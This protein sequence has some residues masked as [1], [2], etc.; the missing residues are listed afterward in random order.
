MN[1]LK[2]N[3][4][5]ETTEERTAF[6]NAY[7]SS[8]EFKKI[9]PTKDELETC[10][11]YILWG[12]DA[13][14]KSS[15]QR[16]EIEIET[17]N[18]TWAKHKDEESLDGLLE[19]P[20]FSEAAHIIH[21]PVR[22]KQPKII[23]SRE[24]ALRDA[25]ESLRQDFIDLFKQIDTLELMVSTYELAHGKRKKPIRKE[26]LDNFSETEI[27]RVQERTSHINQ[28]QYLKLKH[29][30]VEQR[31]LQFTLK[32]GY[33]Q[34]IQR[35]GS[36]L[37][38][39]LEPAP[40][41]NSEVAV[42]PLGTKGPQTKLVFQAIGHLVPNN[43]TEDE[44]SEI[45]K[46]IWTKDAEEKTKKEDNLFF[47]FRNLE[48]VYNFI[49]YF[50]ELEDAAQEDGPENDTQSVLDT[51]QYY[52]EACGFEQIYLDIIEMKKEGRKNQDIADYVNQKYGKS[53]TANYISTIFRQK[54]IKKFIEVVEYHYQVISNLF[55]KENFK[56]CNTCGTVYLTCANNFVRKNRAKDGFSNKCKICDKNERNLK[57][58][59][60]K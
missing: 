13:D 28:Y 59:G 44:L 58:S 51:F 32:D 42:F 57:K 11:N 8:Q 21:T 53:Y 4:Q 46:I 16:K 17:K 43:F 45:S 38:P 6:V 22:Y 15:V 40:V 27:A 39:S 60:G 36:R 3:F 30:L 10:A 55:F 37:L 34:P 41:F 56:K 23:F 19:N 29:L 26:L 54:I 14:G 1:R 5:L 9:P 25:P 48:H 50:K 20:N 18:K 24:N 35:E 49:L 7:L 12:K 47:D 33:A 2:L 52:L 31:K